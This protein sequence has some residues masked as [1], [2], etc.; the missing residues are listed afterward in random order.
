MMKV[1][2]LFSGIGGFSLGLERAGMQTVAF[3][4]VEPYPRRVLAKH[5]PDV[6]IYDDVRTLTANRLAADA[7]SVDVICGG[8]P[9]QDIS[10]AGKGAGIDGE[11]SGLWREYARLIRECRP[12][13]V[14]IENSPFLRNRGADRVFGDLEAAGYAWQSGVVGAAH[15]GA[16]HRR[17]R[18]YILAHA[19]CIGHRT[20]KDEVCAGWNAVELSRAVLSDANGMR[21]LQPQG[22]VRDERGRAGNGGE[23]TGAVLSDARGGNQWAVEPGVGRM[24]HGVPDRVDRLKALGNAVV[25]QVVEMIGRAILASI[26]PC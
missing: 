21:E 15:A 13:W 2:D 24:A 16:P 3:C 12:E 20:A 25:P 1:L 8:F 11:R 5:W 19:G 14:I 26:A 9:C 6:P 18:V 23:E 10:A 17:Q 4:E 7:I 22:G